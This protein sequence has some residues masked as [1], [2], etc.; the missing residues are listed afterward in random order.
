MNKNLQDMLEDIDE[1]VRYTRSMTGRDALDA[2]VMQAMRKVPRAEFVPPDMRH[3]AYENRPLPIGRGQTISQPYIVAL[4]TD[5]IAPG[6]QHSILE[7]GT[8]SGYQTAVL[9]QLCDRVYTVEF[10]PELA[11]A[12]AATLDRLGYANIETRVGDG[13]LGWPERAPFDGIVVTAAAPRIPEALVDQLGNGGRMAIPVGRP[14]DHQ[15]LILIT[16][17]A[18]GKAHARDVLSV[19]FVPLVGGAHLGQ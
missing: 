16:K 6:P 14:H 3:A 5:L 12:A 11:L 17:D 10:V 1:E 19:V 9:A 13:N 15:E 8:G 2:R 18:Q 7:I 4:M